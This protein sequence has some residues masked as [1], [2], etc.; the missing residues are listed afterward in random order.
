[1]THATV[2]PLDKIWLSNHEAQKYLG[3][4]ADFFKRLRLTGKLP[5][6]KVGTTVFYLRRDIDNLIKRGRVY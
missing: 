1:M 6:Y 5:F 2:T 3:I 4:G